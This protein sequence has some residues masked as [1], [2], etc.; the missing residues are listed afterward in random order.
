MKKASEY[1]LHAAECRQ[2]AA[3]MESGEQREQLLGMA[4][5]W[6]E[7]ARDRAALVRLHPELALD[8][9]HAEEINRP[10]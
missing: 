3:K 9:E 8:G 6:D 10:E 1:R 7:L 4:R 2:L 5:H